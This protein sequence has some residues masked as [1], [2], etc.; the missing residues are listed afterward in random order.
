MRFMNWVL[1]WQMFQ[2][3]QKDKNSLLAIVSSKDGLETLPQITCFC[4]IVSFVGSCHPNRREVAWMIPRWKTS[5]CLAGHLSKIDGYDTHSG[6]TEWHCPQLIASSCGDCN[7][8]IMAF[9][10]SWFWTTKL[11]SQS[12]IVDPWSGLHATTNINAWLCKDP[13]HCVLWFGH[14]LFCSG[15]RSL[16]NEVYRWFVTGPWGACVR[17]LVTGVTG[18][19][20]T[21]RTKMNKGR[22]IDSSFAHERLRHH[23]ARCLQ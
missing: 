9:A 17:A 23:H 8:S 11:L 3:F 21:N 19:A 16:L 12:I 4:V 18:D 14:C 20:W 10:L 15:Q 2:D 22:L 1:A 7:A 5:S 6:G 13:C